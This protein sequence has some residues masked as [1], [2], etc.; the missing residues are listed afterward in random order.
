MPVAEKAQEQ[1]VVVRPRP[2]E[3]VRY[4]TFGDVGLSIRS[5]DESFPFQDYYASSSNR[6][7][8]YRIPIIENECRSI[9]SS[10]GSQ[11]RHPL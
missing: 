3:M 9:R 4:E 6:A 10:C 2:Q 8:G 7:G 1:Q 5:V 11:Y